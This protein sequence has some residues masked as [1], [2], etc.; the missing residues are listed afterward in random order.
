MGFGDALL[1]LAG[2]ARIRAMRPDGT[3]CRFDTVGGMKAAIMAGVGV[4]LLPC[5]SGDGEPTL[6]R[7]SVPEPE[8][9]TDL[10][11]L[12]HPDLRHAP[13]IR[14]LLDYLALRLATLRSRIEGLDI[15]DQAAEW[16]KSRQDASQAP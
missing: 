3:A 2:A 11:L 4:G 9:G 16:L 12:T 7:L 1:G 15:T 8:L 13:R 14:L 6:L 5:F 10:W